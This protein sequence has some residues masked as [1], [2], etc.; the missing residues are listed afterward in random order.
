MNDARWVTV[1]SG[2]SL[3]KLTGY[4]IAVN[5]QCLLCCTRCR[6]YVRALFKG[7]SN[8]QYVHGV[9]FVK[10]PGEKEHKRL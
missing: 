8:L 4:D 2:F 10:W 6:L 9:R 5:S 7:R 3:G 1:T